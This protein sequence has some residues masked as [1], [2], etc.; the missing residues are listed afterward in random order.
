MDN[1]NI[2]CPESSSGNEQ[3][4]TSNSPAPF[5]SLIIP[6]PRMVKS[7]IKPTRLFNKPVATTKTVASTPK[8]A[9]S[10]T[11]WCVIHLKL[12]QKVQM[13]I[14]CRRSNG[15]IGPF[16]SAGSAAKRRPMWEAI[17]QC[18]Y[19]VE[20]LGL[21][22]KR[23]FEFKNVD[24]EIAPFRAE[25]MDPFMIATNPFT[26]K[27]TDLSLKKPR[28]LAAYLSLLSYS[29]QY[30]N[31]DGEIHHKNGMRKDG[32]GMGEVDLDGLGGSVIEYEAF[33]N[34]AISHLVDVEGGNGQPEGVKISPA[35]KKRKV[36][37]YFSRADK[38]DRKSKTEQIEENF[39]ELVGEEGGLEKS[40]VSSYVD[41][42]RICLDQL[43]VSPDM[44]LPINETKVQEIA[45]SMADR[46][47]AIY[48]I[49]LFKK[50][51]YKWYCIL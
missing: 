36:T 20:N 17:S 2:S 35:S 38:K 49:E 44:F 26:Q 33:V 8:S 21:N 1:V 50:S 32:S 51:F 23:V 29:E 16:S 39:R 3:P 47:D 15:K 31:Y 37:D 11:N 24:N 28:L 9:N 22:I 25:F 18:E 4:N 43:F 10:K 12:G 46:E 7:A 34:D 41:V 45:D 30:C 27:C 42:V 40:V 6:T 13:H 14:M 19:K 5:S 48:I